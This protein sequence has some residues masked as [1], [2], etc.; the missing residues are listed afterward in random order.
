M[1]YISS[2][3]KNIE[4]RLGD[5]VGKVSIAATI[6]HPAS[7]ARMELKDQLEKIK[8]LA[9]YFNINATEAASE[10]MCF[11]SYLEK[12]QEQT[13]NEIFRYM[14]IS[15]LGDAFPE[16]RQICGII[17][18]CPVGTAGNFNMLFFIYCQKYCHHHKIIKFWSVVR[19]QNSYF[20]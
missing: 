3:C 6:F 7:M 12:H 13:S 15:D 9:E 1:P 20:M 18:T 2:L 17:L 10:W 14:M 8:L 5:A 16:I 4:K 11:R 19:Y